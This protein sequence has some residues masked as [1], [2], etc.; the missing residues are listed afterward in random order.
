MTATSQSHRSGAHQPSDERSQ[1]AIYV[2]GILPGDVE[3]ADEMTGVGEPPG[4]VKL[5]HADDLA[6]LVSEVNL[7]SPLGTP[8]DLAAHKEVLDATA[9]AAAVLPMRFGAVVAS[10][11][12]VIDELLRP[13][14]DDFSAAVRELDSR[15]EYVVKGRYNEQ[16]I[17]HEILSENPDAEQLL[18]RI[19]GKD[20]D[21]TRDLRIRLGELITAAVEAKRQRDTRVLGDAMTGHC[22]ASAV[23]EPTHERDAAHVALLVETGQ[24][25]GMKKAVQDLATKWEGRADVR[26]LGPM[27]AYDFVT[28]SRPGS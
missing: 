23:R 18:G 3:L 13:Y 25:K 11:D 6:A 2:Y 17:L 24:R 7:D 14:H 12:A 1:H 26:L 5:V 28:S 8:E 16:A 21:A 19:R 4:A 20:P 10:E 15:L 9:T 22:V 27:A